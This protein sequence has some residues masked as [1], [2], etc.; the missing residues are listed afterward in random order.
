[1]KRR[2]LLLALVAGLTST[3][4]FAQQRQLPP[5]P[6]QVERRDNHVQQVRYYYIPA[7]NAY[8]DVV[9]K[10]YYY[11]KKNKWVKT[12]RPTKINKNIARAQ[13][14]PIR[15]ISG[16]EMPYTHNAQHIQQWHGQPVR[17]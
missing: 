11:Q 14:E 6:V 5:H 10:V 7:Y 17:R 4:T 2:F 15:D 1:M 9:K 13:R 8:Y 3:T 12:S 16:N